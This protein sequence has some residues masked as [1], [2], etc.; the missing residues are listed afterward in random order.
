MK[1]PWGATTNLWPQ[2]DAQNPGFDLY[3]KLKQGD[4]Q[5]LLARGRAN[6]RSVRVGFV[7]L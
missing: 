4:S 3:L 2:L 6:E 1:F 5:Q 7:V